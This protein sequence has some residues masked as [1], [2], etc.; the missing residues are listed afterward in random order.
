MFTFFKRNIDSDIYEQVIKIYSNNLMQ[1]EIQ[2]WM[3]FRSGKLRFAPRFEYIS[4]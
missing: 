4:K 1:S 3:L 2:R